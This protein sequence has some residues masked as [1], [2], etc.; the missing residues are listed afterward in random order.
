[1]KSTSLSKL[2]SKFVNGD[3]TSSIT[4]LF[5]K[6]SLNKKGM[7]SRIRDNNALMMTIYE[8]L[9]NFFS[10]LERPSLEASKIQ[11]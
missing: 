7:V 3:L 6:F 5:W 1:M 10:S 11:H 8:T 9:K 4:V 2:H